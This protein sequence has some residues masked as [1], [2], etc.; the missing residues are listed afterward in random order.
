[1]RDS[2]QPA[3]RRQPAEQPPRP[4][5]ASNGLNT[6]WLEIGGGVGGTVA[7]CL[8]LCKGSKPSSVSPSQP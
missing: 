4:A 3:T 5:G 2:R 6:K 8:L 1:M 7:L